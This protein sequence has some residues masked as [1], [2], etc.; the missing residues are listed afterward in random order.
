LRKL[1]TYGS[2]G[3]SETQFGIEQLPTYGIQN[4]LGLEVVVKSPADNSVL[5]RITVPDI[6]TTSGGM[7]ATVNGNLTENFNWSGK[8][9]KVTIKNS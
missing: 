8:L 6:V 3:A 7:P 5:K 1:L 4:N 2:A 9:G